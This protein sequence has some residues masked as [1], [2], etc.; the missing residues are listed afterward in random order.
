MCL[1]QKLRQVRGRRSQVEREKERESEGISRACMT[2]AAKRKTANV[3]N[4]E[5]PCLAPFCLPIAKA[6]AA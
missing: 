6:A 2:C 5:K 3:V 1:C 4:D